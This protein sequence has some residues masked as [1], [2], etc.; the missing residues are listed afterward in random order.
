M[1]LSK[2]HI[3]ANTDLIAVDLVINLVVLQMYFT[4]FFCRILSQFAEE[5]TCSN[6]GMLSVFDLKNIASF[7]NSNAI[8]ECDVFIFNINNNNKE[9]VK[10]K[11]LI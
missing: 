3:N 5:G 7:S 11:I 6:I 8:V 2:F 9:N 10:W 1:C 4:V